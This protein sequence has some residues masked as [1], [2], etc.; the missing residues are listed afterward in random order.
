MTDF[1][2]ILVVVEAVTSAMK[3]LQLVLT[4]RLTGEGEADTD[5]AAPRA[6]TRGTS[7]NIVV[8]L[9]LYKL[10]YKLQVRYEYV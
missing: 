2:S 5:E 1:R 3:D 6:T 10:S 9:L 7:V 4:F 8:Q